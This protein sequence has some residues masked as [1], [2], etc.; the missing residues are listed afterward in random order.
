MADPEI[1]D[2]DRSYTTSTPEANRSI[3]QGNGVGA[4]DLAAQREPTE[5][6]EHDPFKERAAADEEE[7]FDKPDETAPDWL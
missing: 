7:T 1:D 3:E 6:A 2:E 5:A 4:R